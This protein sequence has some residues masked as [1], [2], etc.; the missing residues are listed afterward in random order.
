ME[1]VLAAVA[2][3]PPVTVPE[4]AISSDIMAVAQLKTPSDLMFTADNRL[5]I[6]GTLHRIR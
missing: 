1:D 4:V 3:D 6:P 2:I 5:G